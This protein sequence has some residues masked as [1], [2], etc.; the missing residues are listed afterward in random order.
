VTTSRPPAAGTVQAI[1]LLS[2]KLSRSDNVQF[3][4]PNGKIWGQP[5]TNYSAHK[6]RR[7]ELK[8]VIDDTRDLDEVIGAVRAAVAADSRVLPDPAP[9]VTVSDLTENGIT[10]TAQL[11]CGAAD[12]DD[13]KVDL[14]KTRK[15]TLK[16]ALKTATS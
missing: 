5:V 4:L 1:D 2:T 9:A 14:M 6:T 3:I 10:L 15:G 13:L 16:A 12:H 8:L 7:L 11:W